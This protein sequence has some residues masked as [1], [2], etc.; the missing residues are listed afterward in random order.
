MHNRMNY[1]AAR[2]TAAPPHGLDREF[3]EIRRAFARHGGLL[4]GDQAALLM[5]DVFDQP[6]SKL[7]RRV[8]ARE[9][10]R[11][12]W[13]N[14]ILLPLLQFDS[15][16]F[17]LRP[18]WAEVIAEL[19]DLMDDWDLAYWFAVPCPCLRDFIPVDTIE[20]SWE[21]VFDAARAVRFALRG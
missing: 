21:A 14:E 5:R 6:I 15:S 16:T 20:A 12:E 2:A 13:Q 19:R 10:V 9:V 18:G 11:V 3:L 8:V 4:T 7:A 17:A 1:H